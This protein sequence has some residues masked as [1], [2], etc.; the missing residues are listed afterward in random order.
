MQV[1]QNNFFTFEGNWFWRPNTLGPWT[2]N[3]TITIYTPSYAIFAQGLAS[4]SDGILTSEVHKADVW[5]KWDERT[6]E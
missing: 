5:I 6:Q 3:T 4:G 1:D 2:D